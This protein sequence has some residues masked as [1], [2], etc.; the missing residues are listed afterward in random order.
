LCYRYGERDPEQQP[1]QGEVKVGDLGGSLVLILTVLLMA[2]GLIG[3]VVPILPGSILIFGGAL[4]YAWAEGFGAVG[5]PT[6]LVLGMLAAVG[7]TADIWA[8]SLGARA[9]GASVWSMLVGLAGGLV[10]MALFSLP[11][12]ILGAI[13]AVLLAET[14]RLRDV[15]GAAKA[16][17][18]WMLGWLLSTV[19]HLAAGLIMVALFVWQAIIGS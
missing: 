1:R 10:G 6:L 17:G 16:G 3:T 5:W 9:A 12:A 14:V 15:K 2:V 19:V 7:T 4:L 18:G 13:L 8:S 11:G